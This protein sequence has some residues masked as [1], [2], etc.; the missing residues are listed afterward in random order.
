MTTSREIRL[1][2]RPVGVPTADNF[3]LGTV[4]L[5]DPAPGEVQVRNSWMTVDP[6]MRG[7]MNDVKSYSPPFQIGEALQGG[8]VGEVTASND[9]AFKVGDA[10]QSFFG[11]REAFNAPAAMVQKLDTHG[12][13]PQAFLGVAGMP[14]MTAYIGLLRIAALKDGDVVFVS[15]AAGAVGQIVCQIAKLKGHTVIGSAGGADKVAY[16]KEIGVDH[17]IDYKAE[18]DLTAALMRVAPDGIDVYF[19]NVGGA[20]M[21]AALMAA[22]PFGRFALCGMIS[23]YNATD[24]GAGVHGLIVAVGK[25]LRLEGFI[26]SSHADMQIQFI[27]DMSAWI[28]SGKVKWRET[29]EEGIENAPAAF[30]KLFKGENLGKM[31]VRLG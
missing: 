18:P 22:R 16:L 2:S 17:V 3:E 31:L 20:H 9:P 28:A 25:Q 5:P 30:L 21:E 10:V 7:R 29:V 15:A 26:V 14:G 8:A 23:Q 13:P 27:Q 19:E 12:L 24:A 4:Q 6:Y 11:W 1:K